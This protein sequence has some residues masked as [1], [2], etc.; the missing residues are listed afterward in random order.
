MPKTRYQIPSGQIIALPYGEDEQKFLSYPGY[1]NA[2]KITDN[3]N[4]PINGF[5]TPN[6]AQFPNAALDG[7]SDD[8]VNAPMYDQL[9]LQQE[10]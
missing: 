9:K 4:P 8:N 10:E 2:I 7:T 5:T 6:P 1:E 3:S